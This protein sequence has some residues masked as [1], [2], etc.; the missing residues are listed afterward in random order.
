MMALVASLGTP[1]EFQRRLL[2]AKEQKRP[3]GIS[4]LRELLERLMDFVEKDVPDVHVP[5]AIGALLD[6]GDDLLDPGDERGMF[7][8]GN[9]TRVARPVCHLLKRV[10][11]TRR[12]EVL[13]RA[14]G[15]GRGLAV[16]VRLL[17]SLDR[18]ASKEEAGADPALL[19]TKEVKL[20]EAAWVARARE[21]LHDPAVV[22]HG[23]FRWVLQG[24]RQWGDGA[25]LRR[26]CTELI[27]SDAGLLVFLGAFLQHTKSMGATDRMFKVRP[28]LNPA[29]LEPFVDIETVA[30][31]LVTLRERSGVPDGAKVA[32]W[33]FLKEREMLAS[34]KDPDSMWPDDE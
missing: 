18:E 31:R 9:D 13:E 29:W 24:W 11:K 20:L 5:V 12:R 1:G 30:A 10:E 26:V 28:R 7:D 19:T 21:L 33:Q 3:D 32:V 4:K 17:V 14:V 22:A 6:I 25:E 8:V 27:A 15:S 16:Q 23:E 2:A 34:G